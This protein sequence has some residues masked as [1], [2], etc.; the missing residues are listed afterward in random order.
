MVKRNLFPNLF[1]AL[2]VFFLTVAFSS[3]SSSI[4]VSFLCNNRD[5]QIYV[6]DTY[7]GQ[8]LVTYTAPK[9]VTTA[10]IQ[11][12]KDGVTVYTKSIYIKGNNMRLFEIN[13][14]ESNFYSSDRQIHSK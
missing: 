8:E 14:P 4:T 1:C 3:C 11:C 5:L 10:D 12:K 13:V 7:V 6:N 2:V 9:G